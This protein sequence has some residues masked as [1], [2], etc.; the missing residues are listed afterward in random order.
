MP[1]SEKAQE[2][3]GALNERIA[4]AVS[5]IHEPIDVDASL[6]DIE[7]RIIQ[8]ADNKER[9]RLNIERAALLQYQKA[10]ALPIAPSSLSA[11][12]LQTIP[13]LDPVEEIKHPIP[14]ERL[15]TPRAA[16]PKVVPS[17]AQLS[18]PATAVRPRRSAQE[19]MPSD[20]EQAAK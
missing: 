14:G 13:R 4:E 20:Q 10:I 9:D 6:R 12:E 8:A 15:P 3:R 11:R 16:R 7:D 1:R 18:G 17:E 5:K 2:E 19:Y